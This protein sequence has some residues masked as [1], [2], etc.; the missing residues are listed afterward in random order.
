MILPTKHI[1]P[2]RALLGV[3]ASILR[4]LEE[5][6]TMGALWDEVRNRRS[7][8]STYPVLDYR[9]FV[10]ALD[11]LYAIEAVKLERG[12]LRRTRM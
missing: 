4:V 3:G 9:W 12:L 7:E 5:P 8:D 6:K 1:P 10:L 11:L 2:E